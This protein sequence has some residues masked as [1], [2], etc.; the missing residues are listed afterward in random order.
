MIN[1]HKSL[2][3]D[4]VQANIICNDQLSAQVNMALEYRWNNFGW[5]CKADGLLQQPAI[6]DS[7]LNQQIRATR[8]AI[9]TRYDRASGFRPI[10]AFCNIMI[11]TMPG[12]ICPVITAN[13]QRFFLLAL[14]QGHIDCLDSGVTGL[15]CI[16]C[17]TDKE[18]T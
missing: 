4:K 2:M 1:R 12:C 14:Q 15:I 3:P 9:S 6:D 8:A 13:F 16:K 11:Y 18:P 5:C 7:F 17:S 10:L